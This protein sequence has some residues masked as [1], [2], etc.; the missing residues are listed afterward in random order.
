MMGGWG[1]ALG[2]GLLRWYLR[3]FPLREGK[4]WL[5]E[6]C[7]A[8]FLPRGRR[9][10]MK[11]DQGFSLQL[12][13]AEPTQRRIYYYGTYDERHEVRLVQR[14][15]EEGEVFWDVGAN[16]GYFTLAA[17]AALRNTGEVAAFEPGAAAYRGLKENVALNAFGNIR[18]YPVAAAD[19]EGEGELFL[20]GDYA[21]GGASL[22]KG[23]AATGPGQPCRLVRLDR[24]RQEEGLAA[25]DFIKL[26]IEGAE[27]AALQGAKEILAMHQPLL[28]V[29]MKE[30]VLRAAGL[31]KGIIQ[32]F[33]RSLGYRAAYLQRGRWVLTEDVRPVRSRNIFWFKPGLSRHR[34]KAHRI[35]VRLG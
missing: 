2:R 7:H 3:R 28:L 9:V 34:Y 26:D 33:L 6:R 5:Y 32:D 35:P 20:G 19:R 14:L 17:A 11:V 8:P 24:F 22:F 30:S 10:I 31:D 4:G 29:E 16:I 12:D 1:K 21:D 23:P 18:T 27:L 13:L 15:L 25:P